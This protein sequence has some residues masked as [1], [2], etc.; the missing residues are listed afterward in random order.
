[1]TVKIYTGSPV[2]TPNNPNGCWPRNRT[3]ANLLQILATPY[4]DVQ[5]PQ[6]VGKDMDGSPETISNLLGAPPI[7]SKAADLDTGRKEKGMGADSRYRVPRLAGKPRSP[8]T[9]ATRPCTFSPAELEQRAEARALKP[10][11]SLPRKKR[12][13]QLCADS[14]FG[15]AQTHSGSSKDP[16]VLVCSPQGREITKACHAQSFFSL[17]PN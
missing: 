5:S 12:S 16:S 8:H 10:L 13:A 14:H 6:F 17:K 7:G 1:M 3:R 2:W 11:K 15:R 9:V 4:K